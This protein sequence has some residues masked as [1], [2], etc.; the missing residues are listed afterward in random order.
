M[1]SADRLQCSTITLHLNKHIIRYKNKTKLMKKEKLGLSI[2]PV[3][4][5][6]VQEHQFNKYHTKQGHGFAAEDANATHD[7]LLGRHVNKI[8]VSNE[9]NGAD[10]IVDGIKIQSKYCKDA[11]A[12]VNSAFRQS[13]GSYSYIGQKLEVPSDQYEEAI[14]HFSDKI[15]DGKM[16]GVSDPSQARN[17]VKKGVVTYK[18][19]VNI[20][21]AGNVDSLLY[22]AKTHT[23]TSSVAF[24]VSFVLC[25][26]YARYSGMTR[27]NA[28]SY[29]FSSACKAGVVAMATGVIT[30]QAS[31]VIAAEGSKHIANQGVKGT[32]ARTLS[33]SAVRSNLIAGVATVSVGTVLDLHRYRKGRISGKRVAKN[34]GSNVVGTVAGMKGAALGAGFGTAICPGIGT[35]IGGLLGG[36]VASSAGSWV[37]D[38][39]LSAVVRD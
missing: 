7:I 13:D 2:S 30:S 22:D 39:A 3:V 28:L 29:A 11:L 19:A 20:A 5:Q 38:K 24:G 12:S 14:R 21:K 16:P 4:S 33:G 1:Y 15:R 27:R 34:L 32:V 36:V 8:G 10:R 6:T 23:V 35:V 17:Y 25:Y 37:M 18:E 26:A 31:R 9:L